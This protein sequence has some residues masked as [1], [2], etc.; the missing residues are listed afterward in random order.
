MSFYPNAVFPSEDLDRQGV[1]LVEASMWLLGF[2]SMNSAKTEVE[3]ERLRTIYSPLAEI[4]MAISMGELKATTV[5]T[6]EAR[7]TFEELMEVAQ[8]AISDTGKYVEMNSN[9]HVYLK[10]RQLQEWWAAKNV[11]PSAIAKP[12]STIER[13]TLLTIIAVLCKEAKLDYST[14]SK[15]ADLIVNTAA[16]MG[17]SIGETTIR[18]YLKK[19]PDALRT[20]IK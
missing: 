4:E 8:A 2:S 9:A 7:R 13:N 18:N 19:I 14:A 3:K 5:V 20:R 11:I 12:L 10:P 15:T 17:V 1:N 16:G 6:T